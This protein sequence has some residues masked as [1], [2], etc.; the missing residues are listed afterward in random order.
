MEA[1]RKKV[2][3]EKSE[4][5]FLN[6]HPAIERIIFH[7]MGYIKGTYHCKYLGIQLEKGVKDSKTWNPIFKKMNKKI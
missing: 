3:A 4:I 7:L 5:F 1:S 2:N 6:T